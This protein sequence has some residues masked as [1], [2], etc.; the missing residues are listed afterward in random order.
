MICNQLAENVRKA[1]VDQTEQKETPTSIV[2]H[3]Q[4]E[5]T[6]SKTIRIEGDTMVVTMTKD[7][8]SSNLHQ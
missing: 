3:L 7:V 2:Y 8:P 4:I 6:T 1:T 5:L